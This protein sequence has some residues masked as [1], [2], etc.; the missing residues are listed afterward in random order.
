MA[1]FQHQ[2]MAAGQWGAYSLWEQLGNIG[3][4]VDRMVRWAKNDQKQYALSFYRALE[5]LDLTMRDP[6]WSGRL[7]EIARAREL[8]CDA[9]EGGREYGVTLDDMDQYFFH[10]AFA[11]RMRR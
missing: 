7:K 4:E 10:Y 2:E 11:A 3:G 6:R 5:L 1:M 8:L 9:I